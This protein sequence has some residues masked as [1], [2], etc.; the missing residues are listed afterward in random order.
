M[1]IVPFLRF[2]VDASDVGKLINLKQLK[3]VELNIRT[4]EDLAKIFVLMLTFKVE[5]FALNQKALYVEGSYSPE[6]NSITL[7]FKHPIPSEKLKELV[8][9]MCE[10]IDPLCL[11]SFDYSSRCSLNDANCFKHLLILSN[12]FIHT[13]NLKLDIYTHSKSQKF[14]GNLKKL[15]EFKKTIRVD[16]ILNVNDAKMLLEGLKNVNKIHLTRCDGPFEDF[17][18]V[19]DFLKDEDIV[20]SINCQDLHMMSKKIYGLI[21][22]LKITSR[23]E[24]RLLDNIKF[25]ENCIDIGTITRLEI[26]NPTTKALICICNI[27][28]ALK[29]LSVV[30][31]LGLDFT[32]CQ[33]VKN[34]VKIE[35]IRFRTTYSEEG[36]PLLEDACEL[37]KKDNPKLNVKMTF[38]D[39]DDDEFFC[40]YVPICS[41]IDVL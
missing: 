4:F 11:K 8:H 16:S 12:K 31:E 25:I 15:E 13:K 9:I 21:K 24:N 3:E 6:N 2:P 20:F 41:I 34:L 5:R 32:F 35:E 23:N 17:L 36:F 33:F 38:H 30:Q 14:Y 37:L 10:R 40:S 27:F 28:V 39:E 1:K 22:E 7:K 18:K 26:K 29:R 19:K